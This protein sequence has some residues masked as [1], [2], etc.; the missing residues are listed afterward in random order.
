MTRKNARSEK[1]FSFQF[2]ICGEICQPQ[3][4][5]FVTDAFKINLSVS[6]FRQLNSVSRRRFFL[7]IADKLQNCPF[8]ISKKMNIFEDLIDE[9]KEENLLEET[10]VK[11]N[12]EKNNL[13]V[14]EKNVKK[15]SVLTENSEENTILQ[16]DD[17]Q[18]SS[19][20]DSILETE[21][22]IISET[23]PGK[24][25]EE[26]KIEFETNQAVSYNEPNKEAEFFRKR[27][28]DEVS[29]LQMVEHVFAGVEREQM[30]IV[31]KLY[32][33]LNVKKILHT[34]LQISKGDDTNEQAQAEFQLLQETENWYSTLTQRDKR[35]SI[36]H[37]RR[38]CETARPPLS[39][40]ALVSLARFYRNSP[41]SEQV[42]G[43]FDFVITRL[44]SK[45]VA[46]ERR[47]MAFDI[48]ELTTHLKELYAEWSSIPL[49]PNDD[50]ADILLTS[51]QFEDFIT[52]AAV[53]E[54]F[55]NLI[56]NDFFNRL[57]LFKKDTNE[58]FFSPPVVAANIQCNIKIGNR[59]VE[60]LE[61]EQSNKSAYED[62]Y[63]FLHDQ[64]ISDATGKT[65]QLVEL[66]NRKKETPKFIPPQPAAKKEFKAK[67]ETF[68][69]IN[70]EAKPAK[71]IK[72]VKEKPKTEINSYKK[73]ENKDDKSFFGMNSWLL[74]AIIFTVIA[75][76]GIYVWSNNSNSEAKE[77]SGVKKVN[78]E[79]SSLKENIHTAQIKSEIFTASVLPSWNELA[80]EKKEELLKKV[81]SIG[82]DK[83]FKQV[84]LLN[85][86]GK[87]VGFASREKVE[88]LNP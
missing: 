7:N 30:K 22:K 39:S 79:N 87:V 73:E 44:F 42:R 29:F 61:K 17:N 18:I 3:V 84:Q 54:S 6:N 49:Y 12:S 37:L 51:L 47:E 28:V 83:G 52:E 76:V 32:D 11:N 23:M 75:S 82:G 26:T 69:N 34:F 31:P 5:K 50:D 55:D 19:A 64:S 71:E 85:D 36:N 21:Y 2:E 72:T 35:I 56:Q 46:N 48:E 43:K 27:A 1:I 25:A 70:N 9:L 67:T 74:T 4:P 86:K 65:F 63:G 53:T 62:K 78:L 8:L 15:V 10:V 66:L 40:P 81:M 14:S 24:R 57:R 38:Y 60:L 58:N 20:T 16:P 45:D 68:K 77:M 59:Y 80:S 88:I 33:A 41:Y 13:N